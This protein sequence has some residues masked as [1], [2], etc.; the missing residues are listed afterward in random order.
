MKTTPSDEFSQG[1]DDLAPEYAFDYQKAKPNRFAAST[2]ADRQIVVLLDEDVSKVFSTPESV[3][4]ALRA[5]I[6]AMP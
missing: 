5:L 3:N 6:Q 1:A 4:K 2:N